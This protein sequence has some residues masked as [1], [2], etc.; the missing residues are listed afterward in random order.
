MFAGS[1]SIGSQER[2]MFSWPRSKP[3]ETLTGIKLTYW[4]PRLSIPHQRVRG[5]KVGLC[6]SSERT[7]G[8]SLQKEK[9]DFSDP[10]FHFAFPNWSP[11]SSP[12]EQEAVFSSP[13]SWKGMWV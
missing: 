6:R 9:L 11:S 12:E 8:L 13:P 2:R 4:W 1:A 7:M 10:S 5:W 3:S